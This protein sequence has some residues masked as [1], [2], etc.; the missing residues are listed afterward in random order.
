MNRFHEAAE[1]AISGSHRTTLNGDRG[2]PR[3]QAEPRAYRNRNGYLF[4]PGPNLFRAI[5]DAG[6]YMRSGK[7]Q[8]TAAADAC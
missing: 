2:T 7:K 4:V 6:K 1:R 5:I 3:E 8:L